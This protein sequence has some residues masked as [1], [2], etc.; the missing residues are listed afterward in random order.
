[1]CLLLLD[2]IM[3]D[4]HATCEKAHGVDMAVVG[5]GCGSRRSV[6]GKV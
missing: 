1:M 5:G 3:S 6:Q 4:K 2:G